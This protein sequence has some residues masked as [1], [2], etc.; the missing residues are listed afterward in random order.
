MDPDKMKKSG[1]RCPTCNEPDMEYI[2]R[3]LRPLTYEYRDQRGAKQTDHIYTDFYHCRICDH[4]EFAKISEE[5][6]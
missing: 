1:R 3:S 4:I 2:G 5:N 6:G